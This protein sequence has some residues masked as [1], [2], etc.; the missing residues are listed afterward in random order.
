MTEIKENTMKQLMA[1]PKED[2][3]DLFCKEDFSNPHDHS[4]LASWNN[5]FLSSL[6]ITIE[7]DKIKENAMRKLM[8]I[9]KANYSDFF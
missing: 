5:G 3:A 8:A 4:S 7:R 1:I 2:F 6:K 9:Q